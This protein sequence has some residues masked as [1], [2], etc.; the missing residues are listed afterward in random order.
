[1]AVRGFLTC[2]GVRSREFIK[3]P[4]SLRRPAGSFMLQLNISNSAVTTTG[5]AASG[6]LSCVFSRRQRR[7]NQSKS[8]IRLS[9]EGPF[10]RSRDWLLARCVLSPWRA[11]LMNL[12]NI[13]AFWTWQVSH[14][15]VYRD[16][17]STS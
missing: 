14:S 8:Q 10:A 5:S 15:G 3:Y 9:A 12:S 13:K 11:E 6:Y 4:T 17:T 7:P 2:V 1:M 16:K